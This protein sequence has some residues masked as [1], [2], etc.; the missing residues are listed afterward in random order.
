MKDIVWLRR[1][2][3]ISR[4][5]KVEIGFFLFYSFLP[6]LAPTKIMILSRLLSIVVCLSARVIAEQQAPFGVA[7]IERNQIDLSVTKLDDFEASVSQT[8][9]KVGHGVFSEWSRKGTSPLLRLVELPIEVL[10]F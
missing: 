5:L 3:F 6:P 9:D 7:A 4:T 1:K 10:R 2:I 8:K